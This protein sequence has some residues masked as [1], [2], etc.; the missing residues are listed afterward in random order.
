MQYISLGKA[1][2][3]FLICI[4]LIPYLGYFGLY[5]FTVLAIL[6]LTAV[7]AIFLFSK[8]SKIDNYHFQLICLYLLI[9]GWM[10]FSNAYNAIF[11]KTPF[12]FNDLSELIRPIFPML[13]IFLF[14]RFLNIFSFDYL[15]SFLSKGIIF[16]TIYSFFITII[17]YIGYETLEI[18]TNSYGEA[19]IY[20]Q[21]YAQFR[22]FGIIGQPGKQAYFCALLIIFLINL[23]QNFSKFSL[24]FL[25]FINF[26]SLILTFSRTALFILIV[27]VSLIVFIF[28]TKKFFIA[29]I[30]S[31]LPLF[32]L[33]TSDILE[34]DILKILMRG[35]DLESGQFS[36][37]SH[38]MVLKQW[39]LEFISQRFDTI[40][41]GVGSAK[42]YIEQFTHPYATDLTL[43]NPD[44]SFT[45]WYLRYGFVGITL[46][47]LP[48]LALFFIG[49][50]KFTLT[51]YHLSLF[52]VLTISFFDPAFHDI[53]V[54]IFQL[55]ILLF[56]RMKAN[57]KCL[58]S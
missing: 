33:T 16:L 50:K 56:L 49:N 57:K 21:G 9:F 6:I 52:F 4:P 35:I 37:L 45:L 25:I 13:I 38:R 44:S 18:V 48:Y 27:I 11:V 1:I 3:C 24:T 32:F 8:N 17:G 53:K 58:T 14:T 43:R 55:L 12:V 22:S 40:I 34:N 28:H 42:D 51:E 26:V 36:T 29:I 30:F 46:Q 39:A 15:E 10:I 5:N 20:S 19:K 23:R 7:F 41:I 54:M 47:Y 2:L 31:M